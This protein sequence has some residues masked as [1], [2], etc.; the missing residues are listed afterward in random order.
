VLR[1]IFVPERDE[2]MGNG[3]DYI[4]SNFMLCT[5]QQISFG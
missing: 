3:E 1:R 5:P 2:V 4:T